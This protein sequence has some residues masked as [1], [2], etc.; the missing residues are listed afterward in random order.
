MPPSSDSCV[1]HFLELPPELIIQILVQ[2]DVTDLSN[3]ADINNRFLQSLIRDS[4][5]IQYGVD[6]QLACVEDTPYGTRKYSIP[7]RVQELSRLRRAW[8]EFNC[9]PLRTIYFVPCTPDIDHFASDIYFLSRATH[10]ESHLCTEI[11]YVDLSETTNAD[12]N[13]GWCH[14]DV[15]EPVVIFA[16]AIEEHNLMAII[17]YSYHKT[18]RI[19]YSV[20]ILLRDFSTQQPHKLAEQPRI[21]VHD[22]HMDD[23]IP[24]A[25][26]EIV[27]DRL[28]LAIRYHEIEDP[29]DK[30]V[31]GKMLVYNW[32]TGALEADPVDICT[33][34]AT[35]L[36]EDVILMPKA[37]DNRLDFLTIV[38]DG[39][40][41]SLSLELPP[42]SPG[43]SMTSFHCT[44]SP[45]PIGRG[46]YYAKPR[47]DRR[48]KSN[49]EQSLVTVFV[50]FSHGDDASEFIFVVHRS[51]LLQEIR[52]SSSTTERT[53]IPWHAWGPPMVHWLEIENMAQPLFS[54]SHGQR[55][56]WISPDARDTSAP[57]RVMDFNPDTARLLK[58]LDHPV[59]SVPSAKITSHPVLRECRVMTH[60]VFATRVR[61]SL[62]YI[63]TESAEPSYSFT[64]RRKRGV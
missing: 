62:S 26:L 4:V 9:S 48:Y 31:A 19:M 23:G 46:S 10:S 6:K 2:L 33:I 32:K 38:G 41:A 47:N 34:G 1:C 12:T 7:D 5:V 43:Y 40:G 52:R 57:I 54:M 29:I 60:P 35:F 30:D 25:T 63:E 36:A 24:I 51:A 49:T 50:E 45:T 42:L 3:C 14:F 44:G 53:T 16:S 20:W 11:S 13:W 61:S 37:K 21:L 59:R 56:V 17:T 27:G 39:A 8:L 18:M 22:T 15:G 64:R 58:Q 28:L 55:V